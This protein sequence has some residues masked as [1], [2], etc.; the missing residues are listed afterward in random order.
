MKINR[1]VPFALALSLFTQGVFALE[2]MQG[3][4]V[5]WV[6]VNRVGEY[7]IEAEIEKD[8]V[9]KVYYLSLNSDGTMSDFAKTVYSTLL[10]AKASGSKV[11]IASD[12]G[13]TY[14]KYVYLKDN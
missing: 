8:G 10:T 7:K 1:I 13:Q 3:A 4:N 14:I 12:D 11:H 5:N 2:A 6:G 9:K